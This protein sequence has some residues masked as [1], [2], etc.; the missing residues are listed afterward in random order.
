MTL[1]SGSAIIVVPA[2][3]DGDQTTFEKI[4]STA[5]VAAVPW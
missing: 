2:W 5:I 1:R 3:P 4:F